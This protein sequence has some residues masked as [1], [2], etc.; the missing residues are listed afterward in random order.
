MRW[1]NSACRLQL[2]L[3]RVFPNA[4]CTVATGT[5]VEGALAGRQILIPAMPSL[6]RR[7]LKRPAVGETDFPRLRTGQPVDC[8]QMNCCEMRVLAARQKD[9]TRNRDGHVPT[10]A[11]QCRRCDLLHRG[12]GSTRLARDDHV[13]LEQYAFDCDILLEKRVEHRV[14]NDPGDFLAPLDRVQPVHEHFWLDNRDELLLLT[15]S[16]VARQRVGIRSY[17]GG[18]WVKSL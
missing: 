8:I 11:A 2:H 5:A 13:G 16:S 18:T 12:L 15:E 9:D 1:I 17:A 7:I 10:Q 4:R 6:Q 3:I 14:K